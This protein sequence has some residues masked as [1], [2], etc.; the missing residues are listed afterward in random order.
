MTK[1]E[2]MKRLREL[3]RYWRHRNITDIGLYKAVRQRNLEEL[4]IDEETEAVVGQ[5]AR[6]WEVTKTYASPEL[7]NMCGISCCRTIHV[8]L[9]PQ[10]RP[11]KF[12]ISP[13]ARSPARYSANRDATALSPAAQ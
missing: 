11:H 12:Y 2:W 8:S 1:Q 3:A 13:P 10:Q 4:H 9:S 5:F 7:H 6:K